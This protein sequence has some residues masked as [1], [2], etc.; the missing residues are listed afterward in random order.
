MRI[1]VPILVLWAL[2]VAAQESTSLTTDNPLASLKDQL[3]GALAAADL[4]FSPEQERA[5]VLM[6]E[7]R[8]QA[9]EGL[10][11]DL[12]NFRGGPTSGQEADRLRSAI[13]WMRGEFARQIRT[14]LTPEQL[15][16]WDEFEVAAGLARPAG[17]ERAGRGG[18]QAS[19]TQFVRINNNV[20][21][22]ESFFYGRGF[23]G[24][25]GG[26]G[27]G[28]FGGGGRGGGRGGGGGAEVIQRGGIGAWHGNSQLMVKDEAL[29]ARN[30]FASNKPPY[31]ERQFNVDVGGP[32]VPGRLTSE[33]AV[34]YNRSENVGTVRATLPDNSVFA[35]GITRPQVNRSLNSRNTLQLADA[36]SLS[37][38]MGYFKQSRENQGIGDFTLPERASEFHGANWQLE[39]RQFSALSATS[40]Y[41]SRFN[42]FSQINETM[43]LSEEVRVNVLDA[44]EGGGAQNR[45]ENGDR[46]Y[47]FSNLYTRFGEKL[48]IKAGMAGTYRTQR[49]LSTNN[50]GGT[51][52]FS[53]LEAF[54]AGTPLNFRVTRGEPL[55][56]TTQFELGAFV[57][58]DLQV[59]PRF[60]FMFGVRYD[61]QTNLDDNNNVA[62]RLAFA[63]GIGPATVIRGGAGIFYSR[64]GINQ[65]ENQQRLDGTRQ[66]EIV[67]DAP[68]YPDPF[69][70]GSV[71][72]VFPSSVR[73]TDPS[74]QAPTTLVGML[75]V[76]R[77][78][79]RNLLVTATYDYQRDRH[80]FRLRNLNAPRDI[81]SP[82]PRACRPEQDS[83]T[84]VRPD[85]SRGNVVNLESTGNEVSHNLRLTARQRFSIF[86]VTGNYSWQ[87]IFADNP[88]AQLPMDNFN[89]RADWGRGQNARHS[90]NGSLNA[91]LPLDLFV[92]GSISANSG[93]Y[94]SITT[95]KDDNQDS[96]V[97]DRPPGV[98]R[99]GARG[100]RYLNVN[101]NV[102]KAF[103]LEGVATGTRKNINLFA[104]LTN[105]FNRVHRG[106]PSGVLTSPNFGRSTSAFDPREVEIGLR[107]QF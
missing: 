53:S 97:N 74:L 24:F 15:T 29:N 64:L 3:A 59:T 72:T 84:C 7:E 81:T 83:T 85:P 60:S 28:G 26:F 27:G 18:G 80:R 103:F 44:F 36:H 49:A 33:F 13:E 77:T 50:F 16:V 41:E 5:I 69:L 87:D 68:S 104:N 100:P 63:Y 34:G 102:S 71:R 38:N 47:D 20:F 88:G 40:L 30:A 4:P 86:N 22:A 21:T 62:P 61:G 45:A 51:F 17:G 52:T 94:Y 10:F 99:N 9:S 1:V 57:Q 76:E 14:Y 66:H 95:G 32:A 58:N 54:R 96:N 98:P 43:P 105:A 106:T 93:S 42:I 6:M 70:A 75:S 67:I 12:M 73:V 65:V 25:G 2:P 92:S 56:R 31:Q 101:F 90:F 19:Q 46:N 11:G 89:L 23:G 39:L 91:Q 35:L 79:W 37:V 78:F 48:T 82:V 55:F 107:F 8:R